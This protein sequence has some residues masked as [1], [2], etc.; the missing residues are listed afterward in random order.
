M[1][2]AFYVLTSLYV[3]YL[4]VEIVCSYVKIAFLL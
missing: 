3:F 1:I 2:M 4:N